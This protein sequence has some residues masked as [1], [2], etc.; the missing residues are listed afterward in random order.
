MWCPVAKCLH[1]QTLDQTLHHQNDIRHHIQDLQSLQLPTFRLGILY[2]IY[3]GSIS[4]SLPDLILLLLL[5]PL[6]ITHKILEKNIG[7]PHCKLFV[8]CKEQESYA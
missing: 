5:A 2:N 6:V 1:L 7:M 8:T 4:L 3:S